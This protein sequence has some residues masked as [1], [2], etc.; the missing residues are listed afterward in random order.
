MYNL[1][2]NYIDL[3]LHP[4]KSHQD[5]ANEREKLEKV[6]KSRDFS[7]VDDDLHETREEKKNFILD[8]ASF[9]TISWA[10][11]LIFAI[12]S[13]IFFHF[14]QYLSDDLSE[15]GFLASVLGGSLFQKKI[16]IISLL[17]EAVFFPLAAWVYIKFWRV[18]I[19]FFA[20]L[21]DKNVER[22]S[23]DEVVNTSLVGNF[24]LLIPILGKMIK[25]VSQIFYIFIGL[26]HNLKFTTTQSFIVVISPL[27]FIAM[28]MLFMAMYVMLVINLY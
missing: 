7:L 17:F 11:V 2:Y 28:F 6:K 27:I 13:L 3:L 14:G 10:F 23:L 9:A 5:L 1:I 4:V 24:F 26:K 20:N 8:F 25:S 22:E 21:F 18:I 19:S 15:D 16:F 12:Y